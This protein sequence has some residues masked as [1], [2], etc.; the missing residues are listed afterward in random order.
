[1]LSSA[2]FILCGYGHWDKGRWYISA[3]FLLSFSLPGVRKDTHREKRVGLELE[4]AAATQLYQTGNEGDD[5]TGW[6]QHTI[7]PL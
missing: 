5:E 2:G 3:F 6:K 4:I 7:T 1:L